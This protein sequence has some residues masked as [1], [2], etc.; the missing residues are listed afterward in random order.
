MVQYGRTTERYLA[1]LGLKSDDGFRRDL[2]DLTPGHR[3]I[4]EKTWV[5]R[6]CGLRSKAWRVVSS[7]PLWGQFWKEALQWLHMETEV[8]HADIF[9]FEGLS[10]SIQH[11]CIEP[12]LRATQTS[13]VPACHAEDA[14]SWPGVEPPAQ[15][16]VQGTRA[17]QLGCWQGERPPS[18]G[19]SQA[20][21]FSCIRCLKW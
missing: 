12:L 18:W 6:N 7:F 8:S 5:C 19:P 20:W 11:T 1:S 9:A 14:T 13:L 4:S 16:P 2:P 15:L 3:C 10:A 21:A 17:E